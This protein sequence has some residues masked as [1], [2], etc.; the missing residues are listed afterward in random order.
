MESEG[1]KLFVGGITHSTNAA[2]LRE[3]FSKYGEVKSAQVMRNRVTGVSRGFGFVSFTDQSSMERA[4]QNE[5][6]QILGRKVSV[7]IPRAIE[8]KPQ[9]E[10]GSNENSSPPKI[11][12][13]FIGGL[14]PSVT[15]EEFDSYFETFG[16]IID[17]VIM[18][19]KENN[20]SRGF[21][22]VTYDSEES[23][24]KVMAERCHQ[25]SNK[26]VDVKRAIPRGQPPMA[27]YGYETYPGF[28]GYVPDCSPCYLRYQFP[29]PSNCGYYAYNAYDDQL[30][31]PNQIWL[32]KPN[33]ESYPSYYYGVPFAHIGNSYADA[34]YN[35]VNVN[36]RLIDDG[37]CS[38]SN[39]V[40]GNHSAESVMQEAQVVGNGASGRPID[41]ISL[42]IVHADGVAES[43][44]IG[45]SCESANV[46]ENEGSE[47][48]I[49]H[50]DGGGASRN[51]ITELIINTNGGHVSEDLVSTCVTSTTQLP[52]A[53]CEQEGGL[54]SS[55]AEL[56]LEDNG[57]TLLHP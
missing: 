32:N 18:C 17:S 19:N 33:F 38:N 52:S 41:E 10:D 6:H 36:G 55:C 5:E 40:N 53:D 8:Q 13:I 50:A 29:R 35:C 43:T 12:K 27:C 24:E 7:N 16:R 51:G 42:V 3:H 20:V 30:G 49:A 44:L 2:H 57:V 39:S 46:V 22:F 48:T 1:N 9:R 23:I 11:N 28:G 21:G 14:P 31:A 15:K 47:G 45:D 25:L 56:T 34:T 54:I 4:L 26:W 37:R